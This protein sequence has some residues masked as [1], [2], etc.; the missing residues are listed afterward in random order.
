M[1]KLLG[2]PVFEGATVTDLPPTRVSWLL[3]YLGYYGDWLTRQE[4]AFFFRPDADNDTALHYL[5]KLL[6]AARSLPWAEGLEI[7]R[8]RVRWQ[9]P[10]DLA[11]FR[12]AK[13]AQRWGDAYRLFQGELAAGLDA[14]DSLSYDEWLTTE[15][16]ALVDTFAVV[17]LQ[18]ATELENSGNHAEAAEAAR[19]LLNYAPFSEEAARCYA[20][21]TYLF[22]HRSVALG[23]LSRFKQAFGNEFVFGVGAET[24]RLFAELTSDCE[25]GKE[26]LEAFSGNDGDALSKLL[27]DPNVRL[28]NLGN[29]GGGDEIV[30]SKRVSSAHAF[31]AIVDLVEHLL[32]EGHT[33]RATELAMQVLT[34]RACSDGVKYK[35]LGLLTEQGKSGTPFL[36]LFDRTSV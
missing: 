11:H 25:P 30:I 16:R 13:S 1:L 31:G 19:T 35:L 9:V 5:R 10:T 27:L 24:E 15:R 33:S 17:A 21:N 14:S 7:E 32:S 23:F 34:H 2:T 18:Y 29:T 6:A 28:L 4:L 36:A 12:A 8:T 3:V 20:R 22:G 26:G